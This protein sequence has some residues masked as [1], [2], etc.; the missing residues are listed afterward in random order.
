M[1]ESRELWK[2]LIAGDVQSPQGLILAAAQDQT[3]GDTGRDL[4]VA[5]ARVRAM[6]DMM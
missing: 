4:E 5:V 2:K 3:A 6:K 1:K